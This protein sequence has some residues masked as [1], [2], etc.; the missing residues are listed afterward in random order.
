[1]PGFDGT[2]PQGMGPTGGRRGNCG[3]GFGRGLRRFG[4]RFFGGGIGYNQDTRSEKEMLDE[5]EKGLEDEL[6]TVREE[7]KRFSDSK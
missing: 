3:T 4:R 1:M 5:E 2:G 7:K 6:K